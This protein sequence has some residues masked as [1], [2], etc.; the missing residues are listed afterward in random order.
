MILALNKNKIEHVKKQIISDFKAA[1]G[2]TCDLPISFEKPTKVSKDVFR[3]SI[4]V[5][6]GNGVFYPKEVFS[7]GKIAL[8]KTHNG[9]LL[10]TLNS[11][12]IDLGVRFSTLDGG[13]LHGVE[14]EDKN[15]KSF[16]ELV[17]KMFFDI[18][19]KNGTYKVVEPEQ[20][21]KQKQ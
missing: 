2:T 4:E 10:V 21:G 19:C 16:D 1:L 5:V 14:I 12:Y 20:L 17:Q 11:D 3:T 6:E 7:G 18:D 9:T 15:Y 8:A 13:I